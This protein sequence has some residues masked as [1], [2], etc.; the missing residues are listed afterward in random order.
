MSVEALAAPDR[1]VRIRN[2]IMS[3]LEQ[4]RDKIKYAEHQRQ[5][6]MNTLF[7]S[8]KEKIDP[9]FLVH[10]ASDILSSSRECYD[11]C[12]QD[13]LSLLIIPNTGNQRLIERYN[14]NLIHAYFPFY[15]NQLTNNQNPFYELRIISPEFYNYLVKLSQDIAANKEIPNTLFM[16]GD[17][18][19][20][21]DMVNEKKH[22]KL[23]A[24]EKNE[25]QELLIENPGMKMIIP[26]KDQKGWNR[27]K[28]SH[29]SNL[30][31]VVEFRFEAI[32]KEI[33]KFCLFAT[34]STKII[35]EDI[36]SK[37]LQ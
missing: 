1:I 30:S 16:Y 28:V 26:L 7:D 6:L 8:K 32:D 3:R 20:L 33:A 29:E 12:A 10:T 18:L 11:Y 22:N 15:E 21:K 27:I 2:E 14:N 37:Y 19:L 4:I 34:G 9:E 31:R 25:N 36:Y 5:N 35:L 13:I 24:L 17:I 23:I